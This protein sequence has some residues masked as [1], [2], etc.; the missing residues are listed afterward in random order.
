MA[1]DSLNHK[2]KMVIE[3][4]K[5]ADQ[6]LTGS[7]SL[8]GFIVLLKILSTD[9]LQWNGITFSVNNVWIIFFL[10]TVAHYYAAY[11]LNRSICLFWR[12]N[13]SEKAVEQGTLVFEQVTETGGI[14]LRGL[15][16]RT[17]HAKVGYIDMYLMSSIDP[18]TPV[19]YGAAL[20]LIFAMVPWN[21]SNLLLFF[22][23]LAA[24][25]IIIIA[26]WTIAG[27]WI[28]SLS[29]LTIEPNKA[30]HLQKLNN[31]FEK[32]EQRAKKQQEQ[33]LERKQKRAALA[34]SDDKPVHR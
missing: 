33:W 15:V 3:G 13:K 20:L 29:L 28:I 10:L 19:S 16:P 4:A 32:S 31:Y 34:N 17:E 2:Q 21:F 24:S 12:E 14:F 9:T 26:N 22:L 6:I 27:G 1:E 25:I 5:W 11:L 8:A 30:T 23:L 18:S 7:A